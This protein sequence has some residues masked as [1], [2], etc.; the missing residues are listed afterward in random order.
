MIDWLNLYTGDDT[1]PRRFDSP[2]SLRQ[3][4]SRV[5]RLDE[6]GILSLLEFGE[7]SPPL[8]RLSYRLEKLGQLGHAAPHVNE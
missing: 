8:T 6:Q 7:V 5:E 4:L 1:H 3:F 2:A